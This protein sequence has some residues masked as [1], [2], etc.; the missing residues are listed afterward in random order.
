MKIRIRL[1][2][3]YTSMLLAILLLLAIVVYWSAWQNRES[4][5]AAV[6]KKEGITKA[7]LILEAE[8]P[9]TVLHTIY[10]SNR[11]TLD[12]IEVAIYD[13]QYQLVY[14]DAVD[15]DV[16]KETPEMLQA[17]RVKG[18]LQTEAAN[19][20]VLGFTWTHNNKIYIITAAGYDAYG[21]TKLKHLRFTFL[22]LLIPALML[23]IAASYYFVKKALDPIRSMV[24]QAKEMSV[25]E[26]SKRLPTGRYKD[27][28]FELS[29]TINL[30]LEKL[31]GSFQEQKQFVNHVAHELR[32]PLAA[33]KLQVD[34]MLSQKDNSNISDNLSLLR[35]DVKRVQHI[36]D[37]LLNLAKAGYD[38]SSIQMNHLR[39]DEIL[40]EARQE[41]LQANP[42]YEIDVAFQ[43]TNEDFD[44]PLFYGNAYLIRLAFLN[45]MDNACKFSNLPSCTVS[46][47]FSQFYIEVWIQDTGIGI[48][49][50]ELVKVTQPFYR[51]TDVSQ[52]K[53]FGIGLSLVQRVF[54]IHH[55]E[56]KIDSSLGQGTTVYM[57]FKSS[58]SEDA[59]T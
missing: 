40:M 28:L 35:T 42:N 47:R 22:W 53:G 33:M 32:T 36:L 56:W 5:Y 38:P 23:V 26:L 52:V 19:W 25:K 17:I 46:I 27:E 54:E 58:H 49:P 24:Y 18:A 7:N 10:K 31:N 57:L 20:Q 16:V 37:Q 4:A 3:L 14:H 48:E 41:L 2:L 55:V 30:L 34:L 6:L 45:L 13:S 39:L 1:T 15:I 9:D 8:L 29:T 59:N 12:E 50:K 11:Q 43:E 51:T 44:W 21:W